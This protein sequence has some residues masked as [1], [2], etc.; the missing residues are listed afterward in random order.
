MKT[1]VIFDQSFYFCAG[2]EMFLWN[3]D[4]N[5]RLFTAMCGKIGSMNN[6]EEEHEWK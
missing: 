2:N 3:K 5:R 6:L 1:L 4:N